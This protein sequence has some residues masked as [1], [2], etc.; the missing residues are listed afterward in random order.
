MQSKEPTE[1]QWTHVFEHLHVLQ[2]ERNV[3]QR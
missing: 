3:K 1:L 2:V